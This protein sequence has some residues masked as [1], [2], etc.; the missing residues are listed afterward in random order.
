MKKM[1]KGICV[2]SLLVSFSATANAAGMIKDYHAYRIKDQNIRTV[3][4]VVD[5]ILSKEVEVKKLAKN[6]Y[7]ATYGDEHYYM[8]FY[9][10]LNDT[11]V[12][13]VTDGEY[14]KNNNGVTDFFK[15]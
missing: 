3:V 15:S 7:Y 14:D 9:P 1:L 12:Y 6:A 11:D 2:L 5:D 8:K 4:P 13:I 10:A